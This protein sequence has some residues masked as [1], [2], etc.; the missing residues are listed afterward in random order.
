[1]YSGEGSDILREARLRSPEVL[2][3]LFER[4]SRRFHELIHLRPGKSSEASR[5]LFGRT[6]AALTM[7]LR[8]AV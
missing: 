1:M 4:Y 3:V 2:E 5:K 7:K 8:E 6:K